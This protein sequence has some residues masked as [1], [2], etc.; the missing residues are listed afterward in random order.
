MPRS[1][2]SFL[3]SA[4]LAIFA[5]VQPLSA[6][7]IQQHNSNTVSFGNWI[8][9]SNATLVVAAPN[10]K[11]SQIYAESGTPVFKLNKAEAI[12]GVYRYELRAAVD[13]KPA[14]RILSNGSVSN[15]QSDSTGVPYYGTGHFVVEGGMIIT[16]REIEE[17]DEG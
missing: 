1:P 7:P 8:G 14:V 15:A 3:L 11:I 16:P 5:T 4:S 2:G 9:L 17:E 13:E 6:D 10:G 12:D